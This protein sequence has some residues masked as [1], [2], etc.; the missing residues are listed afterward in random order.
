MQKDNTK[1][2]LKTTDSRTPVQVDT[3]VGR[4]HVKWDPDAPL[5]PMGQSVF[6][7]Q[8]LET[9]GLFQ[10]W[11]ATCP[12]VYQSSNSPH[13]VNILGTL[14]L[15]IL[16]GHKRY[17]HITTLRSDHVIPP[18]F[19]MDKVVSEDSVRR[20]FGRGDEDQVLA[21]LRKHLQKTYLPLLDDLDT[22]I[23]LLYG[24]QEGA[25]VGYN[26]K[27]PGRPSHAYHSFF[28]GG[29]R[30]LLD[31]DVQP[32]SKWSGNYTQNRLWSFLDG[33]SKSKK[34]SL[35]RG[36]SGYGNEPFMKE[37]E[38]RGLN[39]LLKLRQT[40]RV[41]KAIQMIS[42]ADGMWETAGQGW[43]GK[44]TQVQLMG[45]SSCRSILVLRRSHR[46]RNPRKK[47]HQ[48]VLPGC[49]LVIDSSLF[50][51]SV[52]VT[53]LRFGV[54]ETAQLYRD[55]ADAENPYDEL[56]NQ[57]GWSGFVTKDIRRCRVVALI[58]SLVYNWWSLYV[59]L[60]FGHKHTEAI[61]SR[62]LLLHTMARQTFH[63]GQTQ[64][65]LACTHAKSHQIQRAMRA[66]SLFLKTFQSNAEQLEPT[67]I[68]KRILEH[69]YRYYLRGRPIGSTPYLA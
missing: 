1:S 60:A 6:F 50:E 47:S 9:A 69:I 54:E 59:R 38:A 18:L 61:T 17:A 31:I 3:A 22:T 44:W 25:D 28:I 14:M 55:R 39:F 42:S 46:K 20:A 36:D 23:K 65:T 49:E 63:S 32:G 8:F 57:W 40:P 15:S 13:L 51:Y 2:Q 62:P 56:K 68:W 5:T 21:W 45:W 11:V 48:D 53:N 29:L 58:I 37:A 52:L 64:I 43:E 33:L 27:K 26:P 41:V 10:D 12:I 67:A 24:H 7:A 66:V 16:S 34:P 30:L 35:L 4:V 19:G